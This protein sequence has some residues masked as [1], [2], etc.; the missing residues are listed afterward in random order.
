MKRGCRPQPNCMLIKFGACA[1][2]VAKVVQERATQHGETIVHRRQ[3]RG[4]GERVVPDDRWPW[5]EPSGSE[6]TRLAR[7]APRSEQTVLY[8][9]V[10]QP[11]TSSLRTPKPAPV[12][13]SPTS[14]G[15]SSTP[16]SSVASR[17]LRP[18]RLQIISAAVTKTVG[19]YAD[20]QHEV[21]GLK[22]APAKQSRPGP[23][24][25]AE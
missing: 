24:S 10:K 21:F 14:R 18:L 5:V 6:P 23:S 9:L 1:P 11:A 20:S 16:S 15:T 3:R 22:V 7:R 17:H 4:T 19:E 2:E 13:N 25:C 8:R 12:A